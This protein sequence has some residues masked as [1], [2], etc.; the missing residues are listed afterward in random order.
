LR[1]TRPRRAAEVRSGRAT[2]RPATRLDPEVSFENHARPAWAGMLPVKEC[3]PG[4]AKIELPRHRLISVLSL[5]GC[6]QIYSGSAGVPV[7]AGG[8]EPRNTPTTRKRG[9]QTA[10]CRP[11]SGQVPADHPVGIGFTMK[12]PQAGRFVPT[13][14]HNNFDKISVCA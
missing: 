7:K 3:S 5:L 4:V 2:A 9:S 11:I 13:N 8:I 12:L 14:S 1:T 10:N 6:S